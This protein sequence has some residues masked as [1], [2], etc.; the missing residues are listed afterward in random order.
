MSHP[1]PS[2]VP[3]VF[4]IESYSDLV[5]A[6]RARRKALGLSQLELDLIAGWAE[7]YASKL[8]MSD[9]PDPRPGARSLGKESLPIALGALQ[10][11]LVL[12]PDGSLEIR[13]PVSARERGIRG[14]DAR[15]RNTTPERRR[16]IARKAA[17][18][19]WTLKPKL[20]SGATVS[21]PLT[22]PET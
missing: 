18:A 22:R 7:G 8:E 6:L 2:P 9:R 11:K 19:R 15:Q 17:E 5:A 10:A 1:I 4:V 12:V 14:A 16:E 3:A 13:N 20:G 21:S